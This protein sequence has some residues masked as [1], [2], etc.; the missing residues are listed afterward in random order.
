VL[1]HAQIFKAKGA[2]AP[3]TE[4]HLKKICQKDKKAKNEAC[5]VRRTARDQCNKQG[6]R[7]YD[8]KGQMFQTNEP[9][10]ASSLN[11]TRGNA[12]SPCDAS[13]LVV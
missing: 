5:N 9:L 3:Q 6:T 8:S 2:H 4:Y 10:A 12:V 1:E 7:R 13:R 11:Q